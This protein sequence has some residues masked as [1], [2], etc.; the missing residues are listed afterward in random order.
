MSNKTLFS[1]TKRK[2]WFN[3]IRKIIDIIDDFIGKK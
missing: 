3:L 2:G 1:K